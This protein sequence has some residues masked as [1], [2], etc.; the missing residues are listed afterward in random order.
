M[1]EKILKGINFPGLKDTY[2]IPEVDNTLSRPG[3]SADAKIVGVEINN[4]KK[5]VG[6][7][8]VADQIAAAMGGGS[9]EV[10]PDDDF[11]IWL[12]EEGVISPVASSNGALYISNNNEIYIL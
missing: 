5:L 10:V 7:S 2:I 6:N 11:L 1:A 8:S 9:N 4:L 3:L 12:N